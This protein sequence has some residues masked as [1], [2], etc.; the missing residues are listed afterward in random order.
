MP[1]QIRRSPNFLPGMGGFGLKAFDGHIDR[2]PL[3]GSS[4]MRSM[5][6]DGEQI[7][8]LGIAKAPHLSLAFKMF[9]LTGR[10]LDS[11]SAALPG[12]RVEGFTTG[13][14]I[15]IG[16]TVSDGSANYTLPV[17]F[18]SGTFYLVAYLPGAPDVAGTTVNT[19]VA[20]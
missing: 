4:G 1:S 19:L 17:G 16:D 5:R 8:F 12:C 6:Q 13:S 9:S 15:Y 14:D 3:P 20:T 18:N 10:T 7:Q 2:F 11:T